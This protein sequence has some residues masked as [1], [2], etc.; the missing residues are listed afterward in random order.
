MK[1][2]KRYGA[3]VLAKR[4]LMGGVDGFNYIT[5]NE[6]C[7]TQVWVNI[8]PRQ[9]R[10]AFSPDYSMHATTSSPNF[11]GEAISREDEFA[12]AE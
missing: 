2:S 12:W 9:V 10:S 11:V 3:T 5:V 8:L 6:D 7:Q 4:L 1:V